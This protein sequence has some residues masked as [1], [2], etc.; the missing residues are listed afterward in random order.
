MESFKKNVVC[1]GPRPPILVLRW[2]ILESENG[3]Q[4]LEGHKVNVQ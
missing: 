4:K 2:S 1:F 3:N